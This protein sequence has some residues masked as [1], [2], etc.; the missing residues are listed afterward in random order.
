MFR[1]FIWCFL[2]V[3]ILAGAPYLLSQNG[4]VIVYFA[5]NSYTLSLLTF[6]ILFLLTLGGLEILA[7]LARLL[8][9]GLFG[10]YLNRKQRRQAKADRLVEKGLR[11]ALTGNYRKAQKTLAKSA[12]KANLP[13][14]NLSQT[15]DLAIRNGNP[16][17][18]KDLL[19]RML[20]VNQGTTEDKKI[21]DISKLKYFVATEQWQKASKFL[22]PIL[23]SNASEEVY[24]IA[25]KVYLHTNQFARL[26]DLLPQLVKH[27]Y[28]SA[29]Q[30][31]EDLA[32]AYQGLIQR[33]LDA[34]AQKPAALIAWFEAQNREHRS[35]L[36][37]RNLVLKALLKLNAYY[38]AIDLAC[39]TLRRC[40]LK[41]V[42]TSEYFEL[43]TQLPQDTLEFKL[44]RTLEKAM[45]KFDQESQ[46][47]IMAI[48]AHLYYRQNDFTKAQTWIDQLLTTQ[49]EQGLSY[50]PDNI[51][52]AQVVYRKNNASE[53]LLGLT[54]LIDTQFDLSSNTAQTPSHEQMSQEAQKL[55]D[56]KDQ[57][58]DKA[59]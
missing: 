1:V 7:W 28:L 25:R 11:Q 5:G 39:E 52:L 42:A 51:L 6:L 16:R 48:L 54:N 32:W 18:A 44:C 53:K 47:K 34:N 14:Y 21:L 17:L 4:Q 13:F 10:W 15:F 2:F 20:E 9:Q 38:E 41:E 43:L 24:L 19:V 58:K 12:S 56:N 29:E 49:K 46:L 45:R 31:Q 40:E 55:E 59:E 57:N 35:S 8:Y 36:L 37:F 30:A 23:R 26:E 27:K 33:Q 50:T 22:D 3:V